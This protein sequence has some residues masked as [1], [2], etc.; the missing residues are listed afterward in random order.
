MKKLKLLGLSVSIVLGCLPLW[1]LCMQGRPTGCPSYMA[2]ACSPKAVSG[3]KYIGKD[4]AIVEVYDKNGVMLDEQT[5]NCYIDDFLDPW[6]I[7]PF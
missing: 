5:T 7:N 4:Y 2:V 6:D 1:A 3:V